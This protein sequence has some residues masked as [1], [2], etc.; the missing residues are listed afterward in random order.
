MCGIA[1]IMLKTDTS[2]LRIGEALVQMLDG[3]QHRGPD[4]TGFAL[5]APADEGNLRLRF[6][7]GEGDLASEATERIRTVL[8]AQQARV[9][10]D[11]TVAR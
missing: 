11:E 10:D 4:S 8:E 7:V 5:Y 6:F 9:I 3:C 2:H 1:G